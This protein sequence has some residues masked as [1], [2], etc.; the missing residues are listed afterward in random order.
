E[1][2]ITAVDLAPTLAPTSERTEAGTVLSVRSPVS[3]GT[4]QRPLAMFDPRASLPPRPR[5]RVAWR[6]F[7]SLLA[8]GALAAGSV[9]AIRS[10]Q[11]TARAPE[12]PVVASVT[13]EATTIEPLPGAPDG[14][15]AEASAAREPVRATEE[16][17]AAPK[18]TPQAAPKPK[19]QAAP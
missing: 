18:P 1:R 2:A 12:Q 4:E 14:A 7:G 16:P 3:S 10:Y 6:L 13:P 19:P 15:V 5:R 8:F 9:L 11:P 17:Q